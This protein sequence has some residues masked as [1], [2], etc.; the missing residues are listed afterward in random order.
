[1]R[2]QAVIDRLEQD[3]AV[4]LLGEEEQQI[5]WPLSKLPPGVSAGQVL[6]IDV[7]IDEAATKQAEAE[8]KA[9][10][11]EIIERQAK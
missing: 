1:M 9:L 10:L 5:V 7:V 3:K 8:S 4:I 11:Q 2:I 6:Q